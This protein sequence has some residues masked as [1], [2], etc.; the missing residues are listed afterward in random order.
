MRK[1]RRRHKASTKAAWDIHALARL[2][3]LYR[4]ALRKVPPLRSLFL[5]GRGGLLLGRV[6]VIAGCLDVRDNRPPV[7][8]RPPGDAVLKVRCGALD[9]GYMLPSRALNV[10]LA[11][12]RY[13]ET[14][15][16]VIY[17]F[18]EALSWVGTSVRCSTDTSVD[19]LGSVASSGFTVVDVL[20]SV[21]R[22]LAISTD[23][24]ITDLINST[25]CS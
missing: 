18:G 2:K 9:G 7:L 5:K 16:L 10:P 17:A 19:R 15:F 13:C 6:H 24:F 3:T 23:A 12:R 21:G 20:T 22:A 14:P 8:S 4:E 1:R 11:P 25:V